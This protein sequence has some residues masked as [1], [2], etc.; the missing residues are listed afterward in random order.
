MNDLYEILILH[1]D[2]LSQEIQQRKSKIKFKKIT[3]VTATVL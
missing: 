2:A 1:T 3:F